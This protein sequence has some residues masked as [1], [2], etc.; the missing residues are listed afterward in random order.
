MKTLRM[1]FVLVIV[2]AAA[3]GAVFATG[4]KESATST[5]GQAKQFLIYDYW[6]AGGE[7]QAIDAVFKMFQDQHPGVQILE[8]QV[9]GGGGSNM[10]RQ[11]AVP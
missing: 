3:V 10:H 8:N 7:K 5:G 11:A 6:T 9:A 2:S 1:F 4:T